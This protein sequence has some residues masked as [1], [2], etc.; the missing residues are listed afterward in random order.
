MAPAAPADDPLAVG[1]ARTEAAVGGTAADAP[2]ARTAVADGGMRPGKRLAH[3]QLERPLGRGGMGEVWLSQDLALDR[4]VAVKVL[5]R[6]VADAPSSRE[7]FYREARAQARVLHANVGHLYYIG[8]DDGQ[9]FFA[10]EYIEGES[11]QARL[12]RLGKLPVAEALEVCRQAAL[13]LREAQRHGF[14]HRDV[15]PSNLMIDRHGRVALLDFGIVK[16]HL[17]I[18]ERGRHAME[19]THKTSV[20]GTP[21]YMAPEQARG[22]TVDFRADIYSLGATLHHMLS[23]KPPFDG[24]TAL[25]LVSQHLTEARP[26][27]ASGRRREQTLEHLVDRMMAK[28]PADRFDSYDDLI[29]ALEQASPEARRPAGVFVRAFAGVLDFVAL[30]AV[31]GLAASTLDPWVSDPLGNV[32]MGAGA[33]LYEVAMLAR[34]GRTLGRMALE[35]EVAPEARA[36]RVTWR[37][38]LLRFVIKLGPLYVGSGGISLLEQQGDVTSVV[39]IATFVVLI[40]LIVLPVLALLATV[41][42]PDRRALWDRAA[43][44]RVCYARRGSGRRMTAVT[45]PH[46]AAATAPT[47]TP[48]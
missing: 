41:L 47:A 10:M 19:L 18:G 37:Q 22:G 44:T 1:V 33:L 17:E 7:R 32:I 11:L 35:I 26:P 16:E 8:E 29:E 24:T 27:L 14:T 48:A 43:G 28:K 36:G 6:D 23:G 3:F 25:E 2:R 39:E 12:E 38:A 4:P 21:L 5:A 31:A 30:L 13:G 34:F 40:V 20:I 42:R 46:D 15:K 9:L 45:S